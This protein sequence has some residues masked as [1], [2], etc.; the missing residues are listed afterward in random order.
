MTPEQLQDLR[1]LPQ[2]PR[3]AEELIQVAG[4]EAAAALITAWPGA[5]YP[6]P[7]AFGR[8][9]T[10]QGQ[11][12]FDMLAEIVGER[13]ARRICGHWGGR[14]LDVPNCKDA[15]WARKQDEIRAMYDKLTSSANDYSHAEAIFEIGILHNVT[16]RCV[17]N[18][19][20]R[21]DNPAGKLAELIDD[22]Q[23]SLF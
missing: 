18:I 19:L 3:T 12:R 17:E 20:S 10:K 4:L 22:G 14:I 13:P 11:R 9:R 8:H 7:V 6:C 5:E 2:F 21:P 23:G 15:L 1:V 16:G